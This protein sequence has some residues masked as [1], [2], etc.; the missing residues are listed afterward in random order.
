[1]DTTKKFQNAFAGGKIQSEG[2]SIY[3]EW[4]EKQMNIFS[5]MQANA[6]V[7][8]S[9]GFTK[10]EEFF[11]N[12]YTQ[13]TA[14]IKQFTDFNQSIYNSF[15]NYGKPVNDYSAN[16]ATMNSA[17]TNIYNS[18]M[19]ALNSS[20]ESFMKNIPGSV[21][22]D[23]FKNLFESNK[24]YMQLQEL[25][26][27]AFKAW[28]NMDFSNDSFRK[29]F[30]AEQYKKVTESMFGQFFNQASLDEV[31]NQSI[32]S[33]H[34]FFVSQNGLTK[35][36]YTAMQGISKEFP[37]L[38]SGDFAKLSELYNG[39]A[40]VFGKTFSPVMNLV[41]AGKEKENVEATIVLMDRIAEY[42]VRKQWKESANNLLKN[43]RKVQTKL[44]ASMSFT[45]SG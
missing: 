2:Q 45:M 11:K 32:K 36:Y 13:Q 28:Q 26:M 7:S 3:N 43:F 10:P 29:F 37:Q 1:M 27:P 12:W 19:N 39:Y 33:I 5:G 35:E 23:V 24:V 44:R 42:A 8:G 14:G 25:Y 21:N 4:L 16:F 40:N 41:A 34:N 9:E 17:W 20:F 6:G 18:W 30:D 22:Q 15:V 31:F 38:V